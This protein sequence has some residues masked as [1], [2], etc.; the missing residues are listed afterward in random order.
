MLIGCRGASTREK[1]NILNFGR[2]P[3]PPRR[4]NAL[5]AHTAPRRRI[6]RDAR[7]QD[8]SVH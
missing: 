8:A 3:R 7:G 5:S 4:V 6:Y 1:F 2:S